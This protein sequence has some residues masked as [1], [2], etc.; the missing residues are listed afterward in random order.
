VIES[1]LLLEQGALAPCPHSFDASEM[2]VGPNAAIQLVRAHAAEADSLVGSYH[3]RHQSLLA[4]AAQ[5]LVSHH[6]PARPGDGPAAC[7]L[8]ASMKWPTAG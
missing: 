6:G 7:C 8:P 1:G 4:P 3:H 5:T 2:G